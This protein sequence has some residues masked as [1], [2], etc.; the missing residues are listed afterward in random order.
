MTGKAQKEKMPAA[1]LRGDRLLTRPHRSGSGGCLTSR[2]RDRRD[3][4]RELS[5]QAGRPS[6]R[7]PIAVQAQHNNGAQRRAAG[8]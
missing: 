8:G 5:M 7:A 1:H 2:D 6:W 4:M 3:L